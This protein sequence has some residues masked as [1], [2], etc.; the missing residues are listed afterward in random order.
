MSKTLVDLQEF[1]MGE[2]IANFLAGTFVKIAFHMQIGDLVDSTI[3]QLYPYPILALPCVKIN[4]PSN[5][6]LYNCVVAKLP[7]LYILPCKVMVLFSS[8]I[9]TLVLATRSCSPLASFRTIIK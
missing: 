2:E 7:S 4:L 9:I 1:R 5:V 3:L 8:S 6:I